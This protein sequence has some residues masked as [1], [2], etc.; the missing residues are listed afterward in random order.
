MNIGIDVDGVLVDLETKMLTYGTKFSV[1]NNLNINIKPNEYWETKKFNWTENQELQFWN[2][3][4]IKYVR[5]SQAREYASEVIEKLMQE[6]NKIY[7]IT[8]R[9]EYGMPK[10][11]YGKMQEITK[12]WLEKNNIKYNKLIFSPDKEKLQKCIENNVDIMIEDSP[13]N[14]L[15]IS[16]K[17][18]VIKYDCTYNQEVQNSNIIKAY[19]WY[20]IYDIINK[21]IKGEK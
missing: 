16:K 17:V 18:K 15:D 4:I 5:D 20:H 6:E 8:A 11:Y 2:Q 9:D 12:N 14:I 1:E 3:Y 21:L 7:I 13:S 10:E 19:S